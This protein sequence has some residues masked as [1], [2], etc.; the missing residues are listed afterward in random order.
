LGIIPRPKTEVLFE[1]GTIRRSGKAAKKRLIKNREW[2]GQLLFMHRLNYRLIHMI[3]ISLSNVLVYSHG[4]EALL[5]GQE[6]L[7]G[8]CNLLLMA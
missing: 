3:E 2:G 7:Q 1:I 8:L 4:G 5:L 6:L